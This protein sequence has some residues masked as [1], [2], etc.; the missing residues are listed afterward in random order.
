MSKRVLDVL[1]SD[2]ILLLELCSIHFCAP[3][4]QILFPISFLLLWVF[5]CCF[6]KTVECS[7]CFA[8]VINLM[9]FLASFKNNNAMRVLSQRISECI[10]IGDSHVELYIMFSSWGAGHFFLECIFGEFAFVGAFV[11]RIWEGSKRKQ[12]DL[13]AKEHFLLNSRE[14]VFR[15]LIAGLYFPS[16]SLNSVL[17]EFV[18]NVMWAHFFQRMYINFPD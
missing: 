5:L 16:E 13:H 6:M 2:R 14:F 10:C 7:S 8:R 4:F 12:N 3:S 15:A 9:F 17:L 18:I 1:I 11:L